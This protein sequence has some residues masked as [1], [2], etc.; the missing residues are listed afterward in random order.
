M[1]VLNDIRVHIFFNKVIYIICL[2]D[3][4]LWLES[5]TETPCTQ[6]SP[7]IMYVK[8]KLFDSNHY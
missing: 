3:K 7:I 2:K 8:L 6:N 5:G 4:P 1:Y